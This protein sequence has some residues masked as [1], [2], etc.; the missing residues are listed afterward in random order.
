[1]NATVETPVTI[2]LFARNR[3]HYLPQTL[4]S[5][6]D[7][8][9]RNW[10]LV[11]SD[12]SS[13]EALAQQN[14]EL[15]REFHRNH[16]NHEVLYVRRTGQWTVMEHFQ[17]AVGEVETPLVACHNDDDLWLP[18]HVEQAVAW[19]S[20]G[21]D[22]VL[23]LSDAHIIDTEGKRTGARLNWMKAPGETAFGDW[24]HIWFS[25]ANSHFGNFPG[26]AFRTRVIQQL[27]RIDNVLNDAFCAIWCTMHG[28]RVKGFETPSYFYRVHKATVTGTTPLVVERHRLL[29][30]LARNYFLT[31]TRKKATFPLIALKSALAL[32][33]KYRKPLPV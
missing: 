25:N 18:H 27:P 6:A 32:K 5:I 22:Y 28:Y 24:L 26:M 20:Q 10:R 31:L 13:D 1:M 29:V 11:L 12:N 8:T 21:E 30:W 33:F 17:L 16:P 4:Q 23:T 14:A 19:L 3:P 7:Q 9:Y 15:L 2:L